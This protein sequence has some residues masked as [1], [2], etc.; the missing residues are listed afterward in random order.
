MKLLVAKLQRKNALCL[1]ES[2]SEEDGHKYDDNRGW[3]ALRQR[4]SDNKKYVASDC[5]TGLHGPLQTH[6]NFG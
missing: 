5:E 1:P 3:N 2:E 6:K 4:G